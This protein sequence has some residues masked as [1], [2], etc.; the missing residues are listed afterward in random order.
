MWIFQLGLIV[1]VSVYTIYALWQLALILY[2]WITYEGRRDFYRLKLI[3]GNHSDV[4]AWRRSL[5]RKALFS[6]LRF[7]L[8]K[9]IAIVNFIVTLGFWLS[10]DTSTAKFQHIFWV[11]GVELLPNQPLTFGV[12]GISLFFIVLTSFVLPIL[13]FTISRTVNHQDYFWEIYTISLKMITFF[14]ILAFSAMDLFS[15]FIFF[16]STLIPMFI[17]IGIWGSRIN[18][19]KAN[20]YFVLY[21]LLGSFLLLAGI[22]IIYSEMGSVHVWILFSNK[23][24]LSKQFILWIFFFIAFAVKIPMLPVHLWLPE[25]H[26]EAPTVGSVLLA[27]LLLKLG[28]YGF[29]RFLIPVMPEASFYFSN[30]V[31]TLAIVSII[32]SSLNT[33]RQ[34]DLKKI[35]AYSSIAHM[36]MVVMGIFSWN[37]QGISGAI[38]LMIGHGIVSGALFLLVGSLY[39][40]FHTRLLRYYGGLAQTM[41]MF[42]FLFFVFNLANMG[43][44]GTI[45]FI[46]EFLIFLGLMTVN[47]VLVIGCSFS[48]VFSA[49]YSLWLFN[50]IAFGTLRHLNNHF[51]D[52]TINELR[53]F[54][55]L[56][57]LTVFLGIFPN[58]ILETIYFSVKFLTVNL[59]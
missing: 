23:L 17:M 29:I 57:V 33:L 2:L 58:V 15:F 37:L 19:R 38:F 4:I 20:F 1:Y 44:P 7:K 3:F 48:V 56:L 55:P 16:E 5:K 34:I 50:R 52:I 39:D 21:T 30:L 14:L 31:Y 18:K 10:F 40:R 8:P 51:L 11:T 9:Y 42:C 47:P 43:F 54:L 24:S 32:Y 26:V 45:N 6:T 36:N 41:P 12:D 53:Y 46:G 25:A 28:G 13:L 35:I 22:L 59:F 49:I 27:S